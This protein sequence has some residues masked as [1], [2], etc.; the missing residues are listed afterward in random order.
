MALLRLTVYL[1]YSCLNSLTEANM[2]HSP[3]MVFTDTV[4]SFPLPGHH[5]PVQIVLEE[6]P[7]TVTSVG[8]KHLIS[9]NLQNPQQTPVERKVLWKEC[10]REH[11]DY[12]ISVVHKRE[13]ANQVFVCGTDGRETLCCDMNLSEQSPTCIPSEKLGKIEESIRE[14]IIQEGEHSALVESAGSADLYITYSGSNDFVGIH[15]FGANK[16]GPAN[17]NNKEQHYVGLVVSRQKPK[18]LQ[19]KVYAFYKEKN[20][21]ASL[22]S[23]MWLPFVTQICMAD[24]GGPKNNL[25]FS[26]TSQLNARLFCGDPTSRQHFSELVDVATVHAQ[27]WQDTTVYALFRNEWGMSAVCVYTIRDIDN[28]FRTSAFKGDSEDRS[29]ECVQ[30]STKITADTLRKIKKTLEMEKWISP[31][32][33]SGPLLFNY[34]SYTRIYAHTSQN[35]SNDHPPVLF[36]SLNNGGVH[37][38][39]QNKTST[40]VNAEYRPFNHTTH[41]L[42]IILHPSS[43]NLYV[44]SRSELVQLDV[45][46]CAQYGD[47]CEQCVLARDPYCGWNSISCTLATTNTLQDVAQGNHTICLSV[48]SQQPVRSPDTHADEAKGSIKLRSQSKY[49]LECPVSSHHAQYTWHHLKSS[50]NSESS[51][52]CNLMEERCLHL[53]DS[54]GPEQVGTY[55]CVSEEMGYSRV[56]AQYQIQLEN[57]AGVHSSCPLVWVCLMAVLIK[58]CLVSLE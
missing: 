25:Q 9:F 54:M 6:K 37:K 40:F 27:E 57:R 51:T 29:R 45:A 31:V 3:R 8:H 23:E 53:I 36:L 5:A 21:E 18:P 33:N 49:F 38:V 11:C 7:H 30:D 15:K 56:L 14:F 22:D 17:N 52:S 44:N 26:W 41:I 43:R 19:D 55:K 39:T 13:E 16:V 2:A 10:S 4:K 34:H 46:N 48:S 47:N 20:K 12:N 24:T 32:G 42:S 35:K 50:P 28:I 58:S 1:L